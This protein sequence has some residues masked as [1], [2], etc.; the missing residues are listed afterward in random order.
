MANSSAALYEAIGETLGEAEDARADLEAQRVIIAK[1]GEAAVAASQAK[2]QF[3]PGTVQ[4]PLSL[5]VDRI[6][7]MES[8]RT[9]LKAAQ[10]AD[11]N[12]LSVVLG[13]DLAAMA[14]EQRAITQKIKEDSAVS[15]FDDPLLALANAFT[16]P[17]DHQALEGVTQKIDT[18]T[19]AMNAVNNHVQQSAK[20]ADSIKQSVNEETIASQSAAVTNLFAAKTANAQLEAAKNNSAAITHVM[21][22]DKNQLDILFHQRQQEQTD[23]RMAMDRERF[24]QAKKVHSIQMSKYE[25][26]VAAE[27]R[28]MELINKA[29]VKDGRNPIDPLSFKRMKATSQKLLDSLMDKGLQL[30]MNGKMTHGD[31][32]LERVGFQHNTG[33]QPKTEQ[34]RSVMEMQGAA[35]K[36]AAEK[37]TSKDKAVVAGEAEKAFKASF[38]DGQ[39]S[40]KEGS[41]FEAPAYSVYEQTA[42]GQSPIWKKYIAPTLTDGNRNSAVQPQ[43]IFEAVMAGVMN[44]EITLGQASDFVTSTFKG[45]VELNNEVHQFDKVTGGLAQKQYGSVL[46]FS[47]TGGIESVLLGKKQRVELTD[48]VQVK[49]ALAKQVAI[50]ARLSINTSGAYPAGAGYKQ[51]GGFYPPVLESS[52]ITGA[53]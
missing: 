19:K 52:V 32:I 38:A 53:K 48:P 34:Q 21:Q 20:T 45:A 42:I 16:L 29:L 50:S 39:K 47:G 30:E 5:Q 35:L 33:Y 22:A 26:E 3:I 46:T 11:F 24:A 43:R 27:A 23:E 28:Q 9:A 17:W 36:L 37:T 49:N 41:P 1:A 44:K 51:G 7:E 14:H 13:Q 2:N 8:Q 10:S 6:A 40:I 4:T 25:D 31:T 12:N 15:L 18:T